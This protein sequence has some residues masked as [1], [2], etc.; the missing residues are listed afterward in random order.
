[1]KTMY[2]FI[3]SL[4]LFSFSTSVNAQEGKPLPKG[5]AK[6]EE[7]LI[8]E[9]NASRAARSG[10]CEDGAPD[11]PVRT[12]AEW[13]E[14]QGLAITWTGSFNSIQSQIVAAAQQEC[15]VFIICSNEN[16]V[17]NQLGSN[18]V[19]WSNNVTFIEDEFNSIWIRDFGPNTVY[20][21]DVEELA[22]VDWIYNRPRPKDDAVPEVISE[23]LDIPIY[24]TTEEPTDV[25]HTGG[26][27]MS[28]GLG[29]GFSS[30]LVLDENDASNQWGVSNHSEEELDQIMEDFMGLTVYPKMEN[31]PFD[32]IHHIDMHMK[33]LD[34]TTILVGE[35]PTGVADGPQIEANI[36]Y[37]LSNYTNAYGEPYRI[38]RIP[39]PP[40]NGVYPNSGADYR[41]YSNA[42]FVNKTILVPTYEQQFDEVAL[43]IWEEAMPGYNVVGINSNA[44]IPLSGAIHCITKEI[45]VDEP[46]W[47]SHHALS[48]QPANASNDYLVETQ[49][50]HKSGISSATMH[51]KTDLTADYTAVTLSDSGNDNWTAS[52]PNQANGTRVYYYIAAEAVDGKSQVRPMPAPEGYFTFQVGQSVSTNEVELG[53]IEMEAVFPN[54][55]SAMTCIP[56]NSP[57]RSQ[58]TIILTDVLGRNV[59]VLFDGELPVGESKYFFNASDLN[60][61]TYFIELKTEFGSK[62][63]NVVVK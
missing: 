1:M 11:G 54:P 33:L 9:Y 48:D 40:E 16:I 7:A 13:E 14:L 47:I 41:T 25:V 50:K 18:G 28:D 34:E 42:V 49:I 20:L 26:N 52:I 53:N 23:V 51:Y 5:F 22:F 12:M 58:A 46:L 6:G 35:Y 56:V 61:G 43:G 39:M 8:P 63:Q 37:I 3:A 27:F 30:E 60:S 17:K 57:V 38:I 4:L 44:I 62:I 45:G 10:D 59:S 31:L 15:E 55:A 19:D 29:T 32:L 36:Q 2:T 24:C 21:N